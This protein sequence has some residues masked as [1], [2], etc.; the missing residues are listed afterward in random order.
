MIALEKNLTHYQHQT[1]WSVS[2]AIRREAACLG[3]SGR[4][5]MLQTFSQP[6]QLW[7]QITSN[8]ICLCKVEYLE[9]SSLMSQGI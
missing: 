1:L 7:L 6:L 4:T 3:E 8:M 2:I 9:A 5:R